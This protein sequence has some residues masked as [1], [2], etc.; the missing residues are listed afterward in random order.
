MPPESRAFS[1]GSRRVGKYGLRSDYAMRP[2]AAR[3]GKGLSFTADGVIEQRRIRYFV[4]VLNGN[5]HLHVLMGFGLRSRF[6]R[7]GSTML[8]I[9]D[10]IDELRAES[11]NGID[12]EGRSERRSPALRCRSPLSL[13][14][15]IARA[16]RLLTGRA[17]VY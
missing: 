2:V 14:R 5:R 16:L 15:W 13:R 7:L 1:S 6:D 10:S 3:A 11:Y 8:A 4:V 9:A 17:F 12:G